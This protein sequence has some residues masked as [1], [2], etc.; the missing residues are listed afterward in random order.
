ME[1]MFDFSAVAADGSPAPP[2]LLDI[3]EFGPFARLIM[4]ITIM[5]G[6]IEF[7]EGALMGGYV[8]SRWILSGRGADRMQYDA[9]SPKFYLPIIDIFHKALGRVSPFLPCQV[10][11]VVS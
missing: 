11:G 1:K 2:C 6:I 10:I 3:R 5:R 9:A 7:G 4:I 8:V